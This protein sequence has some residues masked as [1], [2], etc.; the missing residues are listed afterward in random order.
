MQ[1]DVHHLVLDE[2]L[3]ISFDIAAGSPRAVVAVGGMA[4]FVN[5]EALNLLT[6]DE[7]AL[8]VRHLQGS[9]V[10]EGESVAMLGPRAVALSLH[11]RSMTS[12][13]FVLG[14]VARVSYADRSSSA[15][16]RSLTP[17]EELDFSIEKM[18]RQ[19]IVSALQRTNGNR[20]KAAQ[21]LG[22][23]R[24]SLYRKITLFRLTSV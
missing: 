9:D 22:I 21:L 23:S 7:I 13:N 16:A 12:R 2:F 3:K 1:I 4:S 6:P 10:I 19:Q 11:V 5:A 17:E 18:T 15:A 24:S 8:C 14:R 20:V